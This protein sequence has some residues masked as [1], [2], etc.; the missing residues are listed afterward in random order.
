MH[1]NWDP[2]DE[3]AITDHDAQRPPISHPLEPYQSNDDDSKF[4]CILTTA[5]TTS[6]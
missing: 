2:E 3:D 5:N 4:Y 6:T 1:S